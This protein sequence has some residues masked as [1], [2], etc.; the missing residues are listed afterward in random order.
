MGL[1]KEL[2]ES[3][4]EEW[5]QASPDLPRRS[6]QVEGCRGPSRRCPQHSDI[7][8]MKFAESVADAMSSVEA[9]A[10]NLRDREKEL[11]E[12]YDGAFETYAFDS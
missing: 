6:A 8:P 1:T 3:L 9:A 10:K 4:R 2:C 5:V 11:R 12:R 7:R